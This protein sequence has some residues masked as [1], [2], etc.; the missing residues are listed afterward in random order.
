MNALRF[1][2]P[3]AEGR[4]TITLPPDWRHCQRAEIIVLPAD[5]DTSGTRLNTA[6]FIQRFAGAIPDFPD[7]EAPGPLEE[8]E[9][10]E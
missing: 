5:D 1:I 8:R 6:E 2:Q 3:I 10:L 4:L 9:S 7:I